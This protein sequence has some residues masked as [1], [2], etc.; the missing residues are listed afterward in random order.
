LRLFGNFLLYYGEI[1]LKIFFIALLFALPGHV[2]LKADNSNSRFATYK[3]IPMRSTSA[4]PLATS[5]MEISS[6][7]WEKPGTWSDPVDDDDEGGGGG[8]YDKPGNWDDPFE[9]ANPEDLPVGDGLL[10]L[11]V[12]L[13]AY[14]IVKRKRRKGLMPENN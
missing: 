1:Y 6:T 10:P 5:G 8:G 4:M 12:F 3:P 7:A 9:G 13:V 11:S 2:P 14:A